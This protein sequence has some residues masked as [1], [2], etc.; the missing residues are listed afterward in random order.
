MT[1][2]NL[3]TANNTVAI[4]IA[5]PVAKELSDKFH[6]TGR[7]I[8]AILDCA[9][10]VA[11]G[12][13]PY[14]AQVLIAVGIARSAGAAFSIPQLLGKMYYPY[15]LGILLILFILKGVKAGL[16]RDKQGEEKNA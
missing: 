13:I 6:C 10:C 2:V 7:R 14:G 15:I 8:A 9:S 1:A 16:A 11:Q 5:G 4:V 3:F 12:L